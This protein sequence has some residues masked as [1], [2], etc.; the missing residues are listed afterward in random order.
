MEATEPPLAPIPP[1]MLPDGVDLFKPPRVILP[2][3]PPAPL[4]TAP[5]P[6]PLEDAPPAAPPPL[7]GILEEAG[8]RPVSGVEFSLAAVR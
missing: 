3:T 7:V 6:M 2:L 5:R 1:L 8:P 4:P